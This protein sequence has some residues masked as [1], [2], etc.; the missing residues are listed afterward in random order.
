MKG[1]LL[2]RA[3]GNRYGLRLDQ[4]LEVIEGAKASPAPTVHPSV[5]GVTRMRGATV[6]LVSLASLVADA[7]AP[8]VSSE[9]A[10][11]ARCLGSHIAL[12]V[13]D[14]D[15]V[16]SDDPDVVPDA[17]RLPWVCGVV[18]R[19]GTHLPVIDLDVLAERLVAARAEE[20]T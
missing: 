2:V 11:L 14:A 17:W 18:R 6:P 15:A 9:T 4:V 5:R 13:D 16:L 12:E 7:P 1:Y 20:K 3:G 10:V 19:D 8:P